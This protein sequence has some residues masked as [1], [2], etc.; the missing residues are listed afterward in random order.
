MRVLFFAI[1]GLFTTLMYAQVT[2]SVRG[3]IL[4]SEMFNEPLLMASV[5]LKNT[6]WSDQTNFN[7]NFEITDVAPGEYIMEINFLGYEPL[8]VPIKIKEDEQLVIQESL[9]AK[10][11]T[12]PVMAE[13]SEK[14]TSDQSIEPNY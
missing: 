10:T 9:K 12:I 5:S 4:D 7:G 13:T 14:M 1:A 11:L 8:E 2:G 3:K 6:D